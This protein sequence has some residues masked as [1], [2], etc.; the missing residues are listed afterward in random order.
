MGKRTFQLVKHITYQGITGYPSL[1]SGMMHLVKS[2]AEAKAVLISLEGH[3]E[4]NRRVLRA[5]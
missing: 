5:V 1:G 2:L 4:S 3:H